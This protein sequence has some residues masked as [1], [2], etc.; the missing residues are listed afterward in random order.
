M[1]SRETHPFAKDHEEV[2][3]VDADFGARLAYQA[4]QGHIYVRLVLLSF[5]WPCQVQLTSDV[6]GDVLVVEWHMNVVKLAL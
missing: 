1:N 6:L 3:I 4:I 2:E 5:F